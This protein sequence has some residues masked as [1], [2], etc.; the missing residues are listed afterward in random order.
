LFGLGEYREAELHYLRALDDRAA[1]ADRRA[2]GLYNR[3]VCLV[4]R[5]TDL[6]ALRTAVACFEQAI[7]S[8]ALDEPLRADA[9]YNLELAKLLWAD[10][11]A[12]QGKTD[13]P[14]QLPPEE[15]PEAKPPP[16]A[17]PDP[18]ADPGRESEG[19]GTGPGGQPLPAA[20]ARPGGAVPQPTDRKTAGAGT[21][22][23]LVDAPQAQ[24]LSPDDARAHLARVAERL[25]RDRK[26]NARL[27][28]GP[29]RP[30]VRD[31]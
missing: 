8:D 4:K 3:G 10:A 13:T 21:L 31:W 15:Q 17:G 20:T 12:R 9:R 22:P 23:V 26:A 19:A 11:R 7:E 1:P 6:P 14:N 29:E 30:H 25:D 18:G 28:A 2:K 27:L 5:A 16:A 24:K